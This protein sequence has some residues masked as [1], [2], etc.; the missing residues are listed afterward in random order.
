VPRGW[1]WVGGAGGGGAGRGDAVPAA[2]RRAGA[3]VSGLSGLPDS[4]VIRSGGALENLGHATTLVMDKTGTLTA[5]HPVVVDVLAAPGRDRHRDPALGRLGG[6]MSP[7]VLAE[8]IV[9]EPSRA[10]LSLSMPAEVIE[11]PGRA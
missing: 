3:I 5:G 7:H 1:Q 6:Q 2:A 11:Q 4:V 10:N 9:T 8:A